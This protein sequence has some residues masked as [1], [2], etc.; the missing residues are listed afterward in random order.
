[1]GI[2]HV[3][4]PTIT[5]K[6]LAAKIGKLERTIKTRTVYKAQLSKSEKESPDCNIIHINFNLLEFDDLLLYRVLYDYLNEHYMSGKENFVF[7]VEVQMCKDFEKTINGPMQ[8]RNTIY[9]SLNPS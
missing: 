9:I 7:I 6:E 3:I 5:Q 2:V 8:A 4:E 1:M